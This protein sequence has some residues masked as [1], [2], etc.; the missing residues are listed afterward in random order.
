MFFLQHGT[1][2]K[3]ITPPNLLLP[4][5]IAQCR[6]ADGVAIRQ[7]RDALLDVLAFLAVLG[8]IAWAFLQ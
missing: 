3:P 2:L 5:L 7:V 1:G 4:A 6:W 8:A